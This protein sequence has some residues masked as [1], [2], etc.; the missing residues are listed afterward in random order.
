MLF[1]AHLNH[2]CFPIYSNFIRMCVKS[3]YIIK[4]FEPHNEIRRN[5]MMDSKQKIMK[6]DDIIIDN[7]NQNNVVKSELESNAFNLIDNANY[8][9]NR[10]KDTFGISNDQTNFMLHLETVQTSTP[11]I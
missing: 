6:D 8:K 9:T 10:F 2:F 5:L 11:V 7:E 3:D 1:D 4:N